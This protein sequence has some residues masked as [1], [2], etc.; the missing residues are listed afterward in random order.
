MK[1]LIFLLIII[2]ALG[3]ISWLIFNQLNQKVPIVETSIENWKFYENKEFGYSFK[4]PDKFSN[5]EQLAQGYVGGNVL[6]DPGES[7]IIVYVVTT[8]HPPLSGSAD[9]TIDGYAVIFSPP[10][11]DLKSGISIY[12]DDNLISLYIKNA[13]GKI[14]KNTDELIRKIAS[15]IKLF[16]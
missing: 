12:K 15:T 16:N 7:S 13:N 10:Y 6:I 9:L 2:V 11:G 1:K 3:G 14:N 5:T 4:Y 8:P